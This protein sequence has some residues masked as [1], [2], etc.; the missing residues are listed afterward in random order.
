MA[1]QNINFQLILT[2]LQNL[3][4]ACE[5]STEEIS[6][7]SRMVFGAGSLPGP[8]CGAVV[9]ECL[10]LGAR[11]AWSAWPCPAA[12]PAAGCWWLQRGGAA[13]WTAW[14]GCT[15]T[16]VIINTF[17]VLNMGDTAQG[18]TSGLSLLPMTAVL[19]SNAWQSNIRNLSDTAVSSS[20]LCTQPGGQ[21]YHNSYQFRKGTSLQHSCIT[22]HCGF[23]KNVKHPQVPATQTLLSREQDFKSDSL[24]SSL[25]TTQSS[26]SRLC[27]S[28][29]T[30]LQGF[31]LYKHCYF[32]FLS[33]H[34]QRIISAGWLTFSL[35]AISVKY[36]VSVALPE[37]WL[38]GMCCCCGYNRG[39]SSRGWDSC[40]HCRRNS[41][42]SCHRRTRL[43]KKTK[44]KNPSHTENIQKGNSAA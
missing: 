21:S 23:V 44:Q 5:L 7:S 34:K 43:L 24:R 31:E 37:G 13:G 3:I 26:S 30:E 38:C 17:W 9:S 18:H 1:I 35:A 22:F 16:K 20:A 36:R 29:F 12:A 28:L 39:L 8:W 42:W 6:R 11:A 41:A 14:G 32:G 10:W 25:L 15:G 19:L 4:L 33:S 27:P 2:I 40:H